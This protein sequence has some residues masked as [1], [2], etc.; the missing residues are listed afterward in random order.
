MRAQKRLDAAEEQKAQWESEVE[1][2][3]LRAEENAAEDMIV[4]RY[5]NRR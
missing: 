5:A 4:N 1:K 2:A 3:E